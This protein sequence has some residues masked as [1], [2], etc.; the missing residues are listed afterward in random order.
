MSA[1]ASQITG[2]SIVCSI[3]CSGGDQ[4]KHQSS[5][6]LAIVWGIH[7]WPVKSPHKGPAARKIFPFDDVIMLVGF[8]QAHSC[9]EKA[10]MITCVKMRELDTD[11]NHSLRGTALQKAIDVS[12]ALT[13]WGRDKMAAISQTILSIAFSWMKMLEFRLNF[14]WSLFL[15]VH[16]TIFRHWF[17]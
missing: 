10:G 1:M 16:L 12:I 5:A 4:S 2:V 3:I 8:L 13:H 9:V 17:R 6:S 11:E 7:Q 15:R 14:H